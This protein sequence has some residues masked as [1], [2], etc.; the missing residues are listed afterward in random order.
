MH[1][2]IKSIYDYFPKINA[3][4]AEEMAQQAGLDFNAIKLDIVYEYQ[5]PFSEGVLRELLAKGWNQLQIV[6]WLRENQHLRPKLVERVAHDKVLVIREDDGRY[7]GV[8]GKHRGILQYRDVLAFTEGLVEQ[9][10]AAYVCGGILNS[11]SQ[12]YVVMKTNRTIRLSDTDEVDCYF[13]VSTSHDSTKKLELVFAPLRKTNGTVLRFEGSSVGFKHTARVEQRVKQ[14]AVSVDKINK[15]F[16]NMETS[17]QLLRGVR[18]TAAQLDVFF[19]GLFPDP[20]TNVKRAE[21]IR[22]DIFS[23]YTHGPACQLP[24]TKGTMLGAYF[25][26]VEWVDKQRGVKKSRNRT[27]YDAK[28][29]SLLEGSGAAEKAN[30]YAF[31][32]DL[33]NKLGDVTLITGV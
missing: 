31:A 28:V 25:A 3:N 16:D 1:G 4:T 11:G 2:M 18:P 5:P 10:K 23:I 22:H 12:A 14:A 19:K 26:V 33:V 27:E 15:Y 9:G 7:L 20:E 8:V 6:E 30:A 13:Y 32:L 24:A 29:H 21:D 17:F